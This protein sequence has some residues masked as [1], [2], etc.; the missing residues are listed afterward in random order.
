MQEEIK[1]LAVVAFCIIM[2][3]APASLNLLVLH[4]RDDLYPYLLLCAA[5]TATLIPL[6]AWGTARLNVLHRAAEPVALYLT[7]VTGILLVPQLPGFV[8]GAAVI[9]LLKLVPV[10]WNDVLRSFEMPWRVIPTE[11]TRNAMKTIYLPVMTLVIAVLEFLGY[12]TRPEHD[13]ALL[14]DEVDSV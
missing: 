11:P 5:F 10:C 12:M 9:L 14:K 3:S 1:E 2:L 7:F 13:N 8:C 4:H 6:L